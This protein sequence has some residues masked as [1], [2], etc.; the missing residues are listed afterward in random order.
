MDSIASLSLSHTHMHSIASHTHTHTCIA[1]RLKSGQRWLCNV[2]KTLHKKGRQVVRASD[3]IYM[4]E[5]A[6]YVGGEAMLWILGFRWTAGQVSP[7]GGG[8]CVPAV[9]CVHMYTY[10]T[11]HT[12]THTHTHECMHTYLVT[13]DL[14]QV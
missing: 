14:L 4:I 2:A 1:S 11:H 7:I 3:A 13:I 6:P 8:R 5:M 12:H 9:D 10:N